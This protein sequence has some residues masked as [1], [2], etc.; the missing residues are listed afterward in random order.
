M[1]FSEILF[2]R[3][4]WKEWKCNQIF[5]WMFNCCKTTPFIFELLYICYYTFL[6]L[7]FLSNISTNG[8]WWFTVF[9]IEQPE[10]KWYKEVLHLALKVK[11]APWIHLQLVF[12]II[13]YQGWNRLFPFDYNSI[14]YRKWWNV[15]ASEIHG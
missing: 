13:M 1:Y 7:F 5:I 11:V 12:Y 6:V 8:M 14:I 15:I 4:N 9:V 2:W 10:A 3:S